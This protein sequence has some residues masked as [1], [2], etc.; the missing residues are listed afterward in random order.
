MK[1]NLKTEADKCCEAMQQEFT[2]LEA[3]RTWE[4]VGRNRVPKGTRVMTTRWVHKLKLEANG[5]IRL[6]SRLV[7]RGFADSNSCEL[8]EI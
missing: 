5:T 6:R 1:K 7:V 8:A 3:C 2:A 4:V